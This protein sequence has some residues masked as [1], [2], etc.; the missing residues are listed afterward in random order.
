MYERGNQIGSSIPK[1][2]YLTTCLFLLHFF[3]KTGISFLLLRNVLWICIGPLLPPNG[4]LSISFSV[5]SC[6]LKRTEVSR[7]A[8]KL[9]NEKR[10]VKA[11]G[12]VIIHTFHMRTTAR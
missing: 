8:W 9:T 2:D 1:V 11:N 4:N 6:L 3:H 7:A 10:E 12:F 5:I